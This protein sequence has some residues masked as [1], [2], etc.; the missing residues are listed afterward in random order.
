MPKRLAPLLLISLGALLVLGSLGA[1]LLSVRLG[2]AGAAP[3]PDALAGSPLSQLSTGEAAV[4]EVARL[5]GKDFP[6]TSGAMAVYGDGEAML[7]VSGTLLRWTAAEMVRAME[8]KIALGRS[9]FTPTGTRD[10]D[11]RTVYALTG[12]GQQHFYFQSGNLV[13]WL[14]ADDPVADQALAQTLKFYP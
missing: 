7:W 1:L 6:L 5:H 11:G 2:N 3:V 14:A 9:P 12:M 10:A 4:A 8:E 13:V